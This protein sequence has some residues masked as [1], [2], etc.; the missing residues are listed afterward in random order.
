MNNPNSKPNGLLKERSP[1][2]LQH[3][4]NPVDWFA[5][6][7]EA[8]EKARTENKPIFLSIGYST[9]HWCHVMERESFENDELA[10]YL[11]EHFVSI[12]LDREERPDIDAIYMA[13]TQAMTGS[14]GWPMTVMLTSELKPFFC[15]T[16][17]PPKPAYGKP[18]FRQLLERITE[19]WGTKRDELISSSEG[20]TE[21][22]EKVAQEGND[23]PK[24]LS[25][26]LGDSAISF[27]DRTFDSEFGGFGNAP[28]FPRPVQYGFLFN[29]YSTSGD[30][31][32]KEMALFTLR[33]M[34]LG[35]LNDQIGGGFHRYSVDKYWL[36]SHFEKMLYDQAQLI[37]SYLDAYQIT[38]DK[39]YSGIAQSICDFVIR[40]LTHPEGGFFSA[41]DADSEGEEGTYYIWTL[42]EIKIL[43]GDEHA[44]IFA[45]HFGIEEKG[46]W[47][48]GRNVVVVR[49]TVEETASK[50][51]RNEGS[52][53]KILDESKQIL[54][55]TR[56]KRI[57]PHLDD[58]ILASWNGLM[59]AAMG[60][61]GEVLG[62]KKYIDAANRSASFIWQKLFE[63]T[64]EKLF[65]RWREGE[66]R[67][68][69]TLDTYAFLI[70]G[71]LGLYE[72][73][74]D[75]VWLERSI[76][77]QKEQDENLYDEKQGA[78]FTSREASDIIIRTKN[79]YDG[80]EPSGNSISVLNLL[81]LHAITSDQS[82][83][84]KA[85]RTLLYFAG[86][87]AKYP[88]TMPE[89]LVGMEWHHYAP[90]EIVI[91]GDI[92]NEIYGQMRN[93]LAKYYL[94][95]KVVVTSAANRAS[96]FIKSLEAKEDKLTV[97][98][99]TNQTCELPI[100]DIEGLRTLLEKTRWKSE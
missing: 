89:M 32:A 3:A 28:K 1:Y 15:G 41:L 56:S 7:E 30:E 63:E 76:A 92:H 43:L 8:F 65:H 50:F 6:G 49:H 54:F 24:L 60:R 35:G 9:C 22:I 23:A 87:L 20:L 44:K 85:E 77:L 39:F 21:V 67:F 16:Y 79:D 51:E 82:Y 69:A 68:D 70:K 29:H 34:A 19:L 48:D 42:E 38:G 33:H 55:E 57:R 13:A 72:A 36:V 62:E 2:L 86:K 91:V 61:T 46:N 100:T 37:Q 47:E 97:Y 93:E 40:E 58:K 74:L 14:G 4:Y 10:S 27:F 96:D 64:G 17:F 25:P 95:R 78:Y 98:F 45:Y 11:N 53:S 71:L 88:Y 94:P 5:W 26:T 31:R 80:A 99:C 84:D 52:V 83:K 59:I 81:Q 73:T 66:S 75:D 12:K 18:S 90:T